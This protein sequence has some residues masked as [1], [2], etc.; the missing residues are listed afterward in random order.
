MIRFRKIADA[1]TPPA[2]K[3]EPKPRPERKAAPAKGKPD[4][5]GEESQDRSTEE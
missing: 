4:T 1:E 3:A 2:G 5:D